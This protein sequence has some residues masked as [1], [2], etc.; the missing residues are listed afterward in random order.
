MK[1]FQDNWDDEDIDDDFT[2][3]LREE[4]NKANNKGSK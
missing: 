1:M 2:K 4:L 3:T